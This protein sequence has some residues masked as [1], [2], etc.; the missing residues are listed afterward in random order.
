[1]R[2]NH[3]QRVERRQ[4][5]EAARA[6]IAL[7]TAAAAFHGPGDVDLLRAAAG[8]VLDDA[9]DNR[10]VA[11]R[12][13]WMMAADLAAYTAAAATADNLDIDTLLAQAALTVEE[14][15]AR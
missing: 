4:L 2:R 5:H 15:F 8:R 13:V 1:M 12:L 14:R 10:D 3:Q 6:E 11:Y 7:V 9:L